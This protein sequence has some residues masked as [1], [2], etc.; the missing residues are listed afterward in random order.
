[1]E[2]EIKQHWPLFDWQGKH[3]LFWKSGESLACRRGGKYK[4]L[5]FMHW[6]RHYEYADA[7]RKRCYPN[8]LWAPWSAA[9]D[10]QTSRLKSEVTGL[11]CVREPGRQSHLLNHF[12]KLYFM[13]QCWCVYP[14]I[15][16]FFSSHLGI[17]FVLSVLYVRV[18]CACETLCSS[19]CVVTVWAPLSLFYS[20]SV[21]TSQTQETN[22]NK[23]KV[24]HLHKQL[25]EQSQASLRSQSHFQCLPRT[26]MLCQI[27]LDVR[28]QSSPS[29]GLCLLLKNDKLINILYARGMSEAWFTVITLSGSWTFGASSSELLFPSSI[30]Y[31]FLPCDCFAPAS[32]DACFR[33]R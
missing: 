22:G 12:F 4:G 15:T 28:E 25:Q 32:A 31:H 23:L 17:L 19:L 24:S 30:I 27:I 1:M 7:G 2:Y 8:L 20:S 33:K 9:G 14:N 10:R 5:V 29:K 11:Y 16:L 21:T 13:F 3:G 26:I 18:L 6:R